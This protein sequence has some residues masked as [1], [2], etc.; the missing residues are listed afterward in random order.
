MPDTTAANSSDHEMPHTGGTYDEFR[1][2]ITRHAYA[3]QQRFGELTD[4]VLDA[5]RGMQQELSDDEAREHRL[6]HHACFYGWS[7]VSLLGFIRD[8][9]GDEAAYRAADLV[10]DIGTNGDAPYT[11]DLPYPPVS[12]EAAPR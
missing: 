2:R 12:A 11:E 8:H 7:V 1:T 3:A 5:T 10:D 9:Y 6:A 4:R